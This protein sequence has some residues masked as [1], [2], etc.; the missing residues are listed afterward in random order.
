MLV[1]HTHI[2]ERRHSQFLGPQDLVSPWPSDDA[3]A[4]VRPSWTILEPARLVDRVRAALWQLA[5]RWGHVSPRGIELELA[6]THEGIAAIVGA[7]RSSVSASVSRLQRIGLAERRPRGR[8]RLRLDGR[9]R[10][11]ALTRADGG[12]P[13]QTG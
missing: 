6:L 5:E 9:D 4:M 12:R 13:L 7:E 11:E 10:V 1:E 3:S 8:W 2:G